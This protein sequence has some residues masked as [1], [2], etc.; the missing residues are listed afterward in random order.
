MYKPF[1]FPYLPDLTNLPDLTYLPDLAKS[2]ALWTL[3]F[4]LKKMPAGSLT[5]YSGVLPRSQV[6]IPGPSC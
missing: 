2:T 6:L 3:L 5:T 1:L 4:F